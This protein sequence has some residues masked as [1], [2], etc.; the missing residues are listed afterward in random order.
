MIRRTAP[1]VTLAFAAAAAIVLGVF[2]SVG[3]AGTGTPA[4]PPAGREAPTVRP[5]PPQQTAPPAATPASGS[6]RPTPP[7]ATPPAAPLPALVG[8]IGDSLTVAV[9]ATGGYGVQPQHSWIVGTDATDGVQSHLERLRDLGADPAVVTPARPGAAVGTGVGQ[10]APVVAAAA[11]LAPGATAYVTF[12]LGANDL[13]AGSLDEATGA[14]SFA[15]AVGAAFRTLAAGLPPGSVLVV[16]SVPDVT[17]LRTLLEEVPAAQTLHRRYGVCRSVL[18]ESVATD[19]V[20]DRIRN[21]NSALAAACD[22][23]DEASLDCRHDL[24][25]DPSRSL[26]GATFEREDIS[27]LDWFHPSETGQARIAD[28]AW[29]LTPWSDR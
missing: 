16:L 13:C 11:D 18:G 5:D 12:E 28:E 15:A 29:R 3:G 19:A 25:G 2:A 1:G 20:R 24:A 10:G 22:A 14:D 27:S 4:V 9:N 7:A 26:F 17:R 23:L 21:Y 8:A 6:R